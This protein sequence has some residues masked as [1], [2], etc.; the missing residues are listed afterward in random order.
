MFR[1]WTVLLVLGG[2]LTLMGDPPLPLAQEEIAEVSWGGRTFHYLPRYQYPDPPLT[3]NYSEPL[4]F[5]RNPEEIYL[6]SVPQPDEFLTRLDKLAFPG[7]FCGLYFSIHAPVELE[8]QEI[9]AGSLG[10]GWEV[11]EVVHLP[12]IKRAPFYQII[13][14][15]LDDFKAR[16]IPAGRN[17]IIYLRQKIPASLA[18]ATLAGDIKIHCAGQKSL[19][20]PVQIRVTPFALEQHAAHWL[21]YTA[22]NY[23]PYQKKADKIRFLQEIKDLGITGI[24]HHGGLWSQSAV[25]TFSEILNAAELDGPVIIDF[26]AGLE[27]KIIRELTGKGVANSRKVP[28]DECADPRVAEQFVSFLKDF[29]LWMEQYRPGRQWLYQGIDEPHINGLMAQAQWEYPLARQAGVK[30]SATVYPYASVKDFG[31]LLDVALNNFLAHSPAKAQPF[32]ELSQERNIA[33]WGIMG[34]SYIGQQGYLAVNRL[35]AGFLFL[36][37]GM[38]A[39]AYWSYSVYQNEQTSGKTSYCLAYKRK[40]TSRRMCDSTLQAESLREGIQDYKVAAMLRQLIAQAREN[41]QADA[42]KHS[43]AILDY[44]INDLTPWAD[45]CII[46]SDA[47]AKRNIDNAQ[48]ENMR[49]ALVAEIIRLKGVLK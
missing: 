14:E 17:C 35:R 31:N 46:A 15:R 28:Y 47:R 8:L 34:G 2:S 21:M 16:T 13:P 4:L 19:T 43:Q 6:H 26:G 45:E 29:S 7:E 30:T 18:G 3:Q 44:V 5:Q 25:Q 42:A 23:L 41:G 24:I 48:L 32:R 49:L 1:L 20:L 10:E 37:S 38:P 27:K 33:F 11:F 39:S 12:R 9:D 40:D 22:V 36:K